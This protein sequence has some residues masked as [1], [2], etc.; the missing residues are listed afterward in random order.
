MS[1]QSQVSAYISPET[2]SALEEYVE[3]HGVKKG[4]LIEMALLHHLQA[5]RELPQDVII[6]P[7][8]VVTRETGEWLLDLIENPPA[9]TG[10]MLDLFADRGEDVG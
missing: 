5:L 2:R 1:R 7:R 9:P 8:I 10:G 6:P 4:H 3:A